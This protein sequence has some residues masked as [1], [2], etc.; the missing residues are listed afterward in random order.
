[1][2]IDS[3]QKRAP[4]FAVCSVPTFVMSKDN[5]PRNQLDGFYKA[6]A[7]LW[8]PCVVRAWDPHVSE[9]ATAAFLAIVRNAV[10]NEQWF[11][12]SLPTSSSK[13]SE[14]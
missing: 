5:D 6:V 3:N 9:A 4:L 8:V 7:D 10:S 1:M 13:P 2:D 12:G 11:G 14:I